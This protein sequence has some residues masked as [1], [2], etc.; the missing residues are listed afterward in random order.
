M[1]SNTKVRV[2]I[3][4][5]CLMRKPTHSTEGAGEIREG[6]KNFSTYYYYY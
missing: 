1:S 2:M 6:S 3:A 4:G 5:P